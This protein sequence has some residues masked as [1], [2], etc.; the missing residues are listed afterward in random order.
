MSDM[1]RLESVAPI[2]KNYF[3][4]PYFVEDY[5]I[6]QKVYSN[7]G[8]FA[9]KKIPPT[10]GTDFIRHVHLLYQKGF[11]R[12]VPIYPTL[13]GRYGVLHEKALY[14]LMPWMS[15]EIKEDRQHKHQQLFR[16]LARLHTLSAKDITVKKEER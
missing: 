8:T 11:N 9:L 6:V 1:N 5:G 3:I 12:I 13:D 7:K 10:T 14:Y 4:E 15:N 16:E 2:L